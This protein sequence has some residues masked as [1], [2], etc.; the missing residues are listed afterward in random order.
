MYDGPVKSDWHSAHVF[1]R[2][3]SGGEGIAGAE[4]RHEPSSE[5]TGLALRLVADDVDDDAELVVEQSAVRAVSSS[6]GPHVLDNG[7]AGVRISALKTLQVDGVGTISALRVVGDGRCFGDG[8]IPDVE[9]DAERRDGNALAG[10]MPSSDNTSSG[11]RATDPQSSDSQPL[12][13]SKGASRAVLL[14]P[15][16]VGTPS[17]RKGLERLCR[18][19]SPPAPLSG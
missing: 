8:T 12:S 19:L 11:E 3:D 10:F 1:T 2:G 14:D 15:L 13:D 5:C 9:L 7:A 16:A 6:F 4:C 17:T 18:I